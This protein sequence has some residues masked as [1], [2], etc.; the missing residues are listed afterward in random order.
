MPRS[1]FVKNFNKAGSIVLLLWCL[2]PAAYLQGTS[3]EMMLPG[4]YAEG[5]DIAG[6]L[7]S[8]KLDGVRGYW[9]GEKL[10]SKN[11]KQLQP[12]PAFIMGLPDF[13]L[14]GELWGGRGSFEKTLSIVLKKEAHGGWLQLKFAIF[15]V[16]KAT[17]AFTLRL[18]KAQD[19]FAEHPSLYAFVIPQLPLR[20][21][22]HLQQELQR[23]QDLGGEGLIVRDPTAL[24]TGG[25]ST[26]ILKV[27]E[28]QDAEAVVVDH[29]PGQG[30]NLG[31]LG[32]L[33]VE[34]PNGTRFKIGTGFTDGQRDSPPSLGEVITFKYFGYHLSGI[35]RFPSFLRI[36]GDKDLL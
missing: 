24:Y 2:I 29:L 15:D 6:W 36:R 21:G 30:R 4:V 31:R 13:A 17:G 3:P 18:K 20:H 32:A 26:Q 25:R 12:P 28:F 1:S 19:W 8:E 9:D 34:L 5:D 11:G 33:L 14:E 23:V 35:P 10:W 27:K 7:F 16:P 22:A